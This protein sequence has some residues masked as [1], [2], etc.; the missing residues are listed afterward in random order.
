MPRSTLAIARRSRYAPEDTEDGQIA[1]GYEA[2]AGDQSHWT[3]IFM[4][5]AKDSPLL[6]A[7]V[8]V[9]GNLSEQQADEIRRNWPAN[10]P[11]VEL[12]I[13]FRR[14]PRNLVPEKPGL[15]PEKT[16]FSFR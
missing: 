14:K 15:V 4:T 16:R 8:N 9:L 5:R 13:S 3:S 11:I 1:K 6:N 12:N 7:I 2:H 10:P